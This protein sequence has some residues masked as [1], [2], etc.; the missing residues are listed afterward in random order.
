MQPVKQSTK[1]KL[2]QM[3]HIVR[4][5]NR[6]V[7]NPMIPVLENDDILPVMAVVAKLRGAYLKELF[8]T[9]KTAQS[10]VPT[11]DQLQKLRCCREAYEEMLAGAQALE[12][13]VEREYLDINF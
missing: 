8:H 10:G 9:A 11:E 7:M 3:E 1:K 13:V 2:Q 6:E 5:V 12:V 4:N